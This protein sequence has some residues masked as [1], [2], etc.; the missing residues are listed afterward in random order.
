LKPLKRSF[1][2]LPLL[3]LRDIASNV[4]AELNKIGL[5]MINVN[6]TDI[7]DESG[8]LKAL[9]KEASAKALNE[10]KKSV[11]EQDR[12]G[13]I[14]AKAPELSASANKVAQAKHSRELY[15]IFTFSSRPSRD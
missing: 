5:K 15:F 1:G 3:F 11:A 4:E 9:G 13:E 10:A 6:V 7:K 12:M 8:Y 14:A 2:A